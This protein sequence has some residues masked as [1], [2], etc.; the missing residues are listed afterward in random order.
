M[1]IRIILTDDHAIVVDG[2]KNMLAKQPDMEVIATYNKG[3]DLLNA[4][5]KQQPDVLLLDIQLPDMAGTEVLKLVSKKYPQIKVLMLTSL[6]NVFYIKEAMQ[7]GASGYLTKFAAED[8]LLTAIRQIYAGEQFLPED[9]KQDLMENMF[10][11]NK[12]NT[13]LTPLTRREKEILKL[14]IEEKTNHEI[15][16]VLFISA[17][18]VEA[19]RQSLIFKLGVKN[20][21]GLV[22]AAMQLGLVN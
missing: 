16:E 15:A 4:L 8:T 22:K 14:I 19:H 6:D 7:H 17:R 21:V 1:P 3:E 9:M 13:Q 11:V 5:K 10:K 2:L 18:T 12:K 20:T